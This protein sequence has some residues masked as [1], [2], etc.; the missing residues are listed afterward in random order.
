MLYQQK[1]FYLCHIPLSAEGMDDVVIVDKAEK[2]TDFPALYQKYE[3]LRSHA[4]NDDGLYSVIRADDIY[5]II[6]TTSDKRAKENA[7]EESRASLVTN[8]EHRVMQNKDQNA[9]QI[10]RN[11]HDVELTLS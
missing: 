5:V 1:Y 6:R 3:E 2:S 8:L 9:Q 7:F 4:C 11:V 10:L